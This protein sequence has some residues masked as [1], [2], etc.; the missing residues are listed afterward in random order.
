METVSL[1]L[2]SRLSVGFLQG[3][4][5]NEESAPDA[6]SHH[7][8][9]NI[10]TSSTTVCHAPWKGS[11]TTFP[12]FGT[13]NGH[14]DFYIPSKKW[15]IELLHKDSRIKQYSCRFSPSGMYG[16]T[17][18]LSDYIVLDCRT[19]GLG[20]HTTVC[21]L[22]AHKSTFLYSKLALDIAEYNVVQVCNTKLVPRYIQQ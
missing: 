7:R 10:K 14:V 16:N 15:G 2:L 21:V 13:T 8:R 18:S 3:P 19:C 20:F 17:L 5:E 11:L 6:F 12:E 9:P 1:S 22:S 4:S